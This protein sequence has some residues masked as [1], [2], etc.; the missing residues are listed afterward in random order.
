MVICDVCQ[1]EFKNAQG[2]NGHR[3]FRHGVQQY[4]VTEPLAQSNSESDAPVTEFVTK[5]ELS[6]VATRIQATLEAGIDELLGVGRSAT[7]EQRQCGCGYDGALDEV[8]RQVSDGELLDVPG[9]QEAIGFHEEAV[10]RGKKIG[11][12]LKV[13]GVIAAVERYFGGPEEEEEISP[14]MF[15]RALETAVNRVKYR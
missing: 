2:L 9:V 8:E 10:R 12:W 5:G 7:S 13:P 15:L 11:G 3:R 4:P 1:R 14:E 6:S